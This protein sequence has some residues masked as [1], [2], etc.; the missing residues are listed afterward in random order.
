MS[1][2][3]PA[4]FG[5]R[6]R[7]VRRRRRTFGAERLAIENGAQ[8][9]FR[10]SASHR[11]SQSPRAAAL[12]PVSSSRSLLVRVHRRHRPC[13]RSGHRR[14]SRCPGHRTRRVDSR[15]RGV[16]VCGAGF[17]DA[18]ARRRRTL[19][20][21]IVRFRTSVRRRA[22]RGRILRGIGGVCTRFGA[23]DT[24]P[25]AGGHRRP[26][27][28]RRRQR[29]HAYPRNAHATTSVQ[30]EDARTGA[31]HPPPCNLLCR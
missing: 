28:Q 8:K 24:G 22:R 29:T 1:T 4:K 9:R 14:S 17:T 20:G 2:Q 19:A 23:R 16:G 13:R 6:R 12:V 15:D 25:E 27:A 10:M 3:A 11:E 31:V 5:L 30:L 18:R 7:H 26:D 21:R